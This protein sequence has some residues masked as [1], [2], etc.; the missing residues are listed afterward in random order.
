MASLALSTTLTVG[1]GATTKSS[2]GGAT[3]AVGH[4]VYQD[5]T[6]KKHL[7]AQANAAATATVEGICATAS[8]DNQ[9]LLI[10]TN[11]LIENVAGLTAGQWYVLSDS[12]A[13]E[14][15]PVG[16]LTTGD[17]STLVG[18][19]PTATSFFVKIIPSGVAVG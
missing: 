9:A 12:V 15:M 3:L 13:G 1:S 16:D 19:A 17:R 14:I 6:T 18:Y 4:V 7:K 10:V 11:G 2:K 8:G 5:P